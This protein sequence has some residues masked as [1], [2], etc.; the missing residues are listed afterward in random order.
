MASYRFESV[1]A[2][3]QVMR[4]TM[5]GASRHDVAEQL[6][7]QGY[8]PLLAEE[9]LGP[10]RARSL[11]QR[12]NRILA[13]DIA[14][15]TRELAAMLKAGLPLERALSILAATDDRRSTDGLIRAVLGRLRQ[16][17]S[18]ADAL[19][20]HKD[21]LPRTYVEMV[22]AG[23]L[24][25]G[26]MLESSLD[27]LADYLQQAQAI[28]DKLTASLVY[29]AILLAMSIL[30]ILVILLFVLPQFEPVFMQSKEALPLSTQLLLGLSH[31]LRQHGF[32]IVL[33]GSV[34]A[35][36]VWSLYRHR[37]AAW[38][39]ETALRLPYLKTIIAKNESA[40]FCHTLGTLL[41]HGVPP[42][43]AMAVAAEGFRSTAFI[44]A[45]GRAVTGIREGA[46]LA[47][48]L[49]AEKLFPPLVCQ[50]A[51]I[52]EETGRLPAMLL[53]AA[54]I[55]RRDVQRSIERMMA[56]LT[57]LLTVVSGVVIAGIIAT[58]ISAI[59]GVNDIAG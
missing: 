57:P 32:L 16:G 49:Q 22:R 5:E 58:V 23:E 27:S 4:G 30:S 14:L 51:R 10:G 13:R 50:M 29:P 54:E 15:L 53:Q 31:A 42:V 21:T 40:G 24:G 48:I 19:A 47:A 20:G 3:G 46:S 28:R 9:S 18:F 11:F 36:V 35:C 39:D 25:G 52:G 37:I 59:L 17:A 26:R 7:R 6:Q 41:A 8:L 12:R 38:W 1:D 55:G 34:G 45:A 56:L 43:Q 44:A 2:V 33:L